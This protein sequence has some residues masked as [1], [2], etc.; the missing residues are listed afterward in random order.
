MTRARGRRRVGWEREGEREGDG[1]Q[2]ERVGGRR[3][4]KRGWGGAAEGGERG[5]GGWSG[6]K[7]DLDRTDLLSSLC[8]VGWGWQETRP[9]ASNLITCYASP[10]TCDVSLIAWNASLLLCTWVSDC[11]RGDAGRRCTSA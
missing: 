2:R 9:W 7:S 8:G 5:G 1:G 4:L 3:G 11:M 10:I 6:E